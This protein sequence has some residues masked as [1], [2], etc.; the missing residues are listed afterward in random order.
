[1]LITSRREVDWLLGTRKYARAT[2]I[3]LDLSAL[4][5]EFAARY[6]KHAPSEH[7]RTEYFDS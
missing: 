6:E 3:S 4:C 2:N 1:M 7:S 5:A